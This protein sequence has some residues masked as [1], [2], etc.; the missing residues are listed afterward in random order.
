MYTDANSV[1]FFPLARYSRCRFFVGWRLTPYPTY[2]PCGLPLI[3]SPCWLKLPVLAIS[4]SPGG[5][6]AYRGYSTTRGAVFCRVAA[7]A[8]PDLR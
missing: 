5:A 8:L 6:A 3:Y 2:G 7:N 1:R 4:K